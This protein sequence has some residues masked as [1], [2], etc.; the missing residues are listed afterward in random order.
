MCVCWGGPLSRY[1]LVLVLT[2]NV[3]VQV[4]AFGVK[5]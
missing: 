5:K 1:G 3:W 2:S 4:V